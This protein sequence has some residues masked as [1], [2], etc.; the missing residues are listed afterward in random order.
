MLD[1]SEDL[2]IGISGGTS[3]SLA[4]I[5][6]LTALNASPGCVHQAESLSQSK[7]INFQTRNLLLLQW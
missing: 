6:N 5:N 4:D 7:S 1:P 2:D 3:E